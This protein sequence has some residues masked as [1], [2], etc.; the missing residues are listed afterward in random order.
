MS[1]GVTTKEPVA[2]KPDRPASSGA[3][4]F[5]EA[6]INASWLH[7]CVDKLTEFVAPRVRENDIVVDFGAGTGTSSA[8][9]LKKFDNKIRLWLVDNSPAWL[10]KAYEFLSSRSNV[11][12]FV[13]DKKQDSFAT[14]SETLGKDSVNHVFSAN[15]IHLIPNLKETFGG[16]FNAIKKNGTFIFNSGNIIREEK[17]DGALMLDS[18]VY[19]VHDIAIK[20]IKTDPQFKKYRDGLYEK[21]ESTLPQRKLVFNYPRNVKEYISTLKETGFSQIQVW[22]KLIKIKYSD[23]LKF[24][25]VRRLQA[26][27]LPEIGGINPSPDEEKDRDKLITMA[28][29]KFFQE[30]KETNPLADGNSFVGEWAYVSALK[31]F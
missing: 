14:L 7:D 12:F 3:T 25:R 26:G 1:I 28:S 23:Y 2:W 4:A 22:Y 21:I 10:G 11:N 5:H 9:I 8:R 13:L 29:L 19:R 17:P 27:M 6:V 30:L 31:S 24:L 20:I 15:T 18:T 16:I